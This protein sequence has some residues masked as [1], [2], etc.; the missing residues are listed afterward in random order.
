MTSRPPS[1]RG[2]LTGAGAMIAAM[3]LPLSAVAATGSDTRFVFVF[4]PGG[5]D[6]T[7]VFADGFDSEVS[8]EPD[9]ERATA[10]GIR[11]VDHPDR[12]AVRGFFERNHAKS[13]V[14]NGLMVRSIAHEIC[15]MIA[16]TGSSSG[17]QADWPA[18]L[19]NARRDAFTLPHLVVDGP[20]FPGY[21]GVSVARTGV[22]G[23]L[24]ALISGTALDQSEV[25]VA[26]PGRVRES[27]I[28]RY[29]VR[30]GEAAAAGARSAA[31]QRLT[32]DWSSAMGKL[33]DLKDLRYAVDFT[34]GADLADQAQVA[35]DVLSRGVSRCVSVA[36]PGGGQGG[37]GWDT[38]AD[39]DVQQS[40]LF[41]GLF[42]GLSLLVQLLEST[43]SPGGGMLADD[44][45][46]VVLS[47][48]GRTPL[49]NGVAGKDHWPY[50]SAMLVGPGLTGSR[51]VGGF[52][53]QFTGE[54]V[55]PGSAEVTADGAV[56][57]AESLGATLLAMA[58]I[59]PE[60][61]VSGV[62]PLTGVLT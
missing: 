54:T 7:R 3:G 18:V 33:A 9:A 25:P 61:Y 32:S 50:T 51:V 36:F 56:L 8:M 29:L 49:L 46:V 28:D 16:L 14:L 57:S 62:A 53:R 27:L 45:V 12:P 41:E 24:E 58:D 48:M 23:Q 60:P 20:S 21:L 30:R 52:D 44:T 40:V 19:G 17:L 2:L 59:D 37:F 39:N 26:G 31:E 13:L 4:A 6:T 42:Q 38:H 10:G 55:D 5:W 47:E 43:P 34:G 22:N 11:F 35:A 15:T 1:R